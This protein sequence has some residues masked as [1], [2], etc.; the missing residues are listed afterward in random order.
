M[1]RLVI[2]VIAVLFL[3]GFAGLTIST[4]AEEG[5]TLG[6]LVAVF[7]IVLMVVGIVGALRNPPE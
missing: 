2:L 3:F 1:T 7:V 6:G 4:I 5:L